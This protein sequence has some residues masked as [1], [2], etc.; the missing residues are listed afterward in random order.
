ML[1]CIKASMVLIIMHFGVLLW[2][3]LF[4]FTTAF[5]TISLVLHHANYTP[6]PRIIIATFS[7]LMFGDAHSM[8]LIQ[9]YRMDRR[10]P[11]GILDHIWVNFWDLVMFILLLWPMSV[12]TLLLTCLHSIIWSLM[13]CLKL[14][15]ALAMMPCLMIFAAASLDLIATC[16]SILIS[17]SLMTL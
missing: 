7:I 8:F 14:W 13:T 11:C 17:S 10:F 3:M 4:H 6:T 1:H 12:T 5:P 9:N 2:N 16:I 15:L